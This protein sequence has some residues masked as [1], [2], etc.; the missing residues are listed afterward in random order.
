[1]ERPPAS[2]I[3]AY[4]SCVIPVMLAAMYWTL[5]PSVAPILAKFNALWVGRGAKGRPASSCA[6]A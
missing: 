3:F 4:A 6:L 5:R 2:I 1:M